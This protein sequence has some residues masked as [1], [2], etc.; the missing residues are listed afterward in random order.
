MALSYLG[1][2][3][4]IATLARALNRRSNDE[5]RRQTVC[6]ALRR[7][8]QHLAPTPDPSDLQ[9]L[10]HA[11]GVA[12]RVVQEAATEGLCNLAAEFLRWPSE[13]ATPPLV[14]L[15]RAPSPDV[16]LR[17]IQALGEVGD[18]RALSALRAETHLFSNVAAPELKAAAA[19]AIA[20]I[21]LRVGVFTNRELSRAAPP[22]DPVPTERSLTRAASPEAE[23]EEEVPERLTAPVE[24]AG[25]EKVE[26]S[27]MGDAAL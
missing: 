23:T 16:R 2:G 15:L 25:T 10:L 8:V 26:V 12:D 17:A 6:A 27:I 4:A 3:R 5:N 13:E 18:A 14:Q 7:I 11:A 1:D 24:E 20:A 21:E 9:P 19:E 22:S